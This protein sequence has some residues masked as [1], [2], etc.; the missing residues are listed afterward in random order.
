VHASIQFNS[1]HKSN[2]IET[3]AKSKHYFKCTCQR[4]QLQHY[5]NFL[6]WS[7][8]KLMSWRWLLLNIPRTITVILQIVLGSSRTTG[9]GTV[10]QEVL[11]IINVELQRHTPRVSW[12]QHPA[13]M[14]RT[15]QVSYALEAIC[16]NT[17]LYMYLP[18]ETSYI[19]VHITNYMKCT[20]VV[21]HVKTGMYQH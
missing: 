3:R 12:Q 1:T 20:S 10:F 14:T 7:I 18:I 2:K 8:T 6:L 19:Y 15:I 16:R 5:Y 4:K 21:V 11:K 17:K 13:P 9:D